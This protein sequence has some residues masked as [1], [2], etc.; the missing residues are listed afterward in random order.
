[1]LTKLEKYQRRTYRK[2][3]ASGI[4]EGSVKMPE[5]M[6]FREM[7]TADFVPW[8][9]KPVCSVR[10]DSDDGYTFLCD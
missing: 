8:T 10:D 1:M 5:G 2:L 6:T 7:L 4:R 9:V 3:V